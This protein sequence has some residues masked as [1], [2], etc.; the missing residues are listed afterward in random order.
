VLEET[1]RTLTASLISTALTATTA[2]LL[3][4]M[5]REKVPPQI[6]EGKLIATPA[7][8]EAPSMRRKIALRPRN[9]ATVT[10]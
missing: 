3:A 8:D 6:A 10:S 4:A 9:R 5:P 2:L 1:G 7:V